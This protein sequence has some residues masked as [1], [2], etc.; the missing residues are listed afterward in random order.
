MA[1]EASSGGMARSARMAGL[2]GSARM[3]R[4]A[5]VARSAW[6][7]LRGLFCVVRFAW[8]G[9]AWQVRA[10][11]A[12]RW[13]RRICKGEVLGGGE[14]VVACVGRALA[15]VCRVLAE[16]WLCIGKGRLEG[17]REWGG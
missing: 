5:R 16:C 1:R 11:R 2:A 8:S 7:V 13:E 6:P 12:S 10:R 9:M 15:C 17:V 3:A 14:V 4:M